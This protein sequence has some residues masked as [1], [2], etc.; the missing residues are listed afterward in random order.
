MKKKTNKYLVDFK[1]KMGTNKEVSSVSQLLTHGILKYHILEKWSSR[2]RRAG[3][4]VGAR[5]VNEKSTKRETS[6]TCKKDS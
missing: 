5:Y 1:V 6:G 2:C 4:G 3:V